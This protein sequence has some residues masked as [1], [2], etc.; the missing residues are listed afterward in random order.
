MLLATA[1]VRALLA[2]SLLAL[3]LVA[4]EGADPATTIEGETEQP[5]PGEPDAPDPADPGTAPTEG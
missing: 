4:C 5:L 3:G 2:A 1:R